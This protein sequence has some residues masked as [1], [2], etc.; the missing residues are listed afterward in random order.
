[1]VFSSLTY[2][3]LFMPLVVASTFAFKS[4]SWK[5]G[6]LLVA[7]VLFYGWGE[8]VWVYGLIFLT[9][10]VWLCATG[11][12][13]SQVKWK[14]Q[15][16]L[17]LA[18]IAPM[19]VLLYTKYGG[20]L[21]SPVL[22]WLGLP[23]PAPGEMPLGISFFTFQIITY[24][25]D[26]Y[27][28]DRLYQKSPLKLL[29]YISCF[30]Q[31]VAGP[32]VCYRDI[33]DEID[34]RHTTPDDFVAGMKRFACGLGK[35]V[36][37]ANVC[38]QMV[39]TVIAN[40]AQYGM[41]VAGGWYMA[42]VYSLQI[43]FDF[44]GYSD[45]A[46]G[47]GRIFGFHYAENFN[48]PYISTGISEFWRRW[49]ISLG[50]FFREYLYIPLGGNRRGKPR[51]FFNLLLVWSLTGLWHGASMNFVL[52]GL[53]FFVL[54][55]AERFLLKPLLQKLPK[56]LKGITTYILV[57]VGWVI[58]Y[59]TDTTQML[60]YLGSLFG[61]GAVP[62]YTPQLWMV[63]CQYSVLP[64]IALSASFPIKNLF[65]ETAKQRLQPLVTLW[66]TLVFVLSVMMIIGQSYNPFIYFRF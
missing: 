27:R 53:Y 48:Y 29:L 2:L 37:L 39:E 59:F 61:G 58:F 35:K 26:V 3:L 55:A 23:I 38:G 49:H 30:P 47:L 21:F 20:F 44:S 46:I 64:L 15:L 9:S 32:I 41:S 57:L 8:P 19:S 33:S 4:V 42:F 13:R 63:V 24:A 12:H 65:S 66:L 43:Y 7:S 18:V 14:K 60:A 56:L 45:M 1:M 50:T 17:A 25:V 31:L 11:M 62:L 16:C 5:N 54:I 52:W 28:D 10:L 40:Q 22:K 36:L 6:V 34:Q 51:Q